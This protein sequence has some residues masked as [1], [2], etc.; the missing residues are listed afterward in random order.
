MVLLLLVV[1]GICL[2]ILTI[3]LSFLLKNKT[4][5]NANFFNDILVGHRG[6][7][8]ACKTDTLPENS[9]PAVKYAIQHGGVN[10]VELD[11][12]L[13]KDGHIIIYHDT[14][15]TSRLCYGTGPL[16]EKTDKLGIG[17]LTLSEIKNHLRYKEDKTGK[18]TL[19]TLEEYIEFVFSL[20][21]NQ[22]IMI[23]VKQFD[24]RVEEMANELLKIY[25][26]FP[27]LYQQSVVAS[28]NPYMLYVVRKKDPKIVTNYLFKKGMIKEIMEALLI[29]K[30]EEKKPSA[31]S[32]STAPFP[33]FPIVENVEKPKQPFYFPALE[34][35][36]TVLDSIFLYL[37]IT[38]IP[39][40]IGAAVLGF[41]TE[42]AENLDFVKDLQKRG[43]VTNVWTVNEERLKKKLQENV[44]LALTTDFLFPK[45]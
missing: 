16:E 29:K 28:F 38:F 23:E 41:N 4:S 35:L 13:T 43:F 21:K 26:K 17:K 18:E 12:Q 34:K 5:P 40:F 37:N 14:T 1:F 20:D 25:K 10:G 39:W 7:R 2:L 42:L 30:V 27:N 19:P 36:T 11:C 31:S 15:N 24:H 3:T 9:L 6:C 45:L 33:I 32:T 22:V 44:K 8:N